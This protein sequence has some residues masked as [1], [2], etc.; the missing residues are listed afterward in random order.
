MV[1]IQM[2]K[3]LP[4][5][6]LPLPPFLFSF[7]FLSKMRGWEGTEKWDLKNLTQNFP[8]ALFETTTHCL[9]GK[10]RKWIRVYFGVAPQQHFQRRNFKG[11]ATFSLSTN[12]HSPFFPTW[13]LCL[14]SCQSRIWLWLAH[15]INIFDA[16]WLFSWW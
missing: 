9:A 6:S 12:L 10:E 1:V 11:K 3:V 16:L 2:S 13:I 7:F 15:Y 4:V 5:Y 14:Q 8:C